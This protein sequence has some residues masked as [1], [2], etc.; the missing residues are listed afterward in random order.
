MTINVQFSLEPVTG[1]NSKIQLWIILCLNFF[2]MV[3]KVH[4]YM[5]DPIW[6]PLWGYRRVRMSKKWPNWEF[7]RA[8]NRDQIRWK[9]LS[10]L[11]LFMGHFQ[12]FME[13]P[14]N[15]ENWEFFSNFGFRNPKTS[16][17]DFWLNFEWKFVATLV[18]GFNDP[19]GRVGLIIPKLEQTKAGEMVSSYD[20]ISHFNCF[21]QHIGVTAFYS[22][23]LLVYVVKNSSCM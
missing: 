5:N 13:F 16:Y 8:L 4:W 7:K 11:C 17:S 23:A 21:R 3:P 2:V 14:H 1:P 19:Q 9:S 15:W 20:Y 10:I 22:E 18:V 12:I 6:T